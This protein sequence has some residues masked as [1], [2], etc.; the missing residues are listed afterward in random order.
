MRGAWIK[1]EQ[2]PGMKAIETDFWK[3]C[4][5]VDSDPRGHSASLAPHPSPLPRGEGASD[6]GRAKSC[7]IRPNWLPLLGERA[8]VRGAWIDGGI[9]GHGRGGAV[10]YWL[11]LL[12]ERAGVG[13]AWINREQPPSMRRETM[14][15]AAIAKGND[16][17][18]PGEPA[19]A[20]LRAGS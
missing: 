14:K 8:G 6:E 12:G 13:G 5:L 15:S 3:E 17:L 1:R 11:P 4:T 19:P 7:A 20:H 10:R 2:S 9:A 18:K 16:D